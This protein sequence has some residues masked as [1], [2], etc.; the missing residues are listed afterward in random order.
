MAEY[1]IV[2]KAKWKTKNFSIV[3]NVQKKSFHSGKDGLIGHPQF[4]I[5]FPL[6]RALV[7]PAALTRDS[8]IQEYFGATFT[9]NTTQDYPTIGC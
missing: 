7:R 9:K 3:T 4:H 1:V 5:C 6:G 2:K 8:V